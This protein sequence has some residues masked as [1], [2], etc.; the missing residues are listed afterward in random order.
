MRVVVTGANGFIGRAIAAEL[1][2]RGH[3]VVGCVRDGLAAR[4]L[5]KAPYAEV[6]EIGPLEK[7]GDVSAIMRDADAIVHTAN[8]AGVPLP[9]ITPSY[10]ADV[11][12]EASQRLC[13]MAVRCGV[14]HFLYLSSTKAVGDRTTATPLCESTPPRPCDLYG[15]SKLR[16]E[17]ALGNVYGIGVT[18]IRPPP[19]YGPGMKGGML[20][21]FKMAQRGIPLPLKN[22]RN[23]RDFL[24]L[25]SLANLVALCVEKPRNSGCHD[26]KILMAT[27][28]E[29]VSSGAL[30]LKIAQSLGTKVRL[31]PF[32]SAALSLVAFAPAIRGATDSLLS[33]LRID[34]SESRRLLGWR[35]VCSMT[36]GLVATAEWY[37]APGR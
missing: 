28:G 11:N 30:Y 20:T 6:T 31:V 13:E 26:N 15:M 32:P 17:R 23:Q 5:E 8:W 4:A 29:P 34:D 12:V 24:A 16:A 37:R 25:P 9:T 22:I 18:I 7:L 36:E 1:S 2:N 35:P 27:D 14:P 33:S 19:V 10:A 3:Q 21:L